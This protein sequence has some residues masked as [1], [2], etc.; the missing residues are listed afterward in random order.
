MLWL[1]CQTYLA[2]PDGASATRLRKTSCLEL[3][4][5]RC[6]RP[7]RAA[8]GACLWCR[9]PCRAAPVSRPACCAGVLWQ[10]DCCVAA[11]TTTQSVGVCTH[12]KS[13]NFLPFNETQETQRNQGIRTHAPVLS[14]GTERFP[15]AV[16][17]LIC[18]KW[19]PGRPCVTRSLA[20]SYSV[21]IIGVVRHN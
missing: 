9:R 3:G 14:D 1:S 15:R 20:R 2:C 19:G 16:V 17:G 8:S 11:T 12:A 4:A 5:G 7:T 13:A 10:F 21:L 18:Y 6:R